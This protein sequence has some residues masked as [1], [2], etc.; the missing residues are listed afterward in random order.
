MAV[1]EHDQVSYASIKLAISQSAVTTSAR[2]LET[3]FGYPLFD[4]SPQG[5][6]LADAG[7]HLTDFL[8]TYNFARS[9]KTPNGLTPYEHTGKNW[10]SGRSGVLLRE[11][12][13]A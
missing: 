10:T 4:R 3:I 12:R 6:R 2:K 13:F 7:T 1:A 5:M 9:L 8:A 11:A